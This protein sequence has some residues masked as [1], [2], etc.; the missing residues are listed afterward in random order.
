MRVLS[1]KLVVDNAES[2]NRKIPD[3]Y[4]E[5]DKS[6]TELRDVAKMGPSTS[7]ANLVWRESKSSRTSIRPVQCY[8]LIRSA[9][10]ATDF[11]IDA[12]SLARAERS[13]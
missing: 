6:F 11:E 13:H 5:P 1:S 9:A 7:C 10:E 2:I 12:S 8:G 3:A 4:F